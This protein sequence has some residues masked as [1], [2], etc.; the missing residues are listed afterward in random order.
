MNRKYTV[1]VTETYCYDI[2]VDA[3][4]G[5]EAVQK[6]NYGYVNSAEEYNGVFVADADSIEGIDFSLVEKAKE[7]SPCK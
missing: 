1:R 2:E 5:E 7:V 3:N 4:S 6:V